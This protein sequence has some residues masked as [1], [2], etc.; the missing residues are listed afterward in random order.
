MSVQKEFSKNAHHYDEYNTIQNR[1][2]ED[3]IALGSKDEKNILDLGCG[4]GSV[5]KALKSEVDSFLGVD[6][7]AP[8][9]ELHPKSKNVKTVL[10]S[11]NDDELFTELAKNSYD[12]IYSASAL[13]W[14]TDLDQ[15]FK[16]IKELGTPISFS[17]FTSNTFKTIY[18]V[19]ELNPL[20]RSTEVLKEL[21]EKYFDATITTKNYKLEFESKSEMFSYIKNSGV[22]SGQRVLNYR[23]T[24]KLLEHYPI[25]YLEFEVMFIH[26]NF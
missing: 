6:F 8:M 2:V 18:E 25:N 21:I 4:S 23:Q 17:I 11:F 7:S 13:Q 20:L 9:L 14:A 10:G 19:T 1:V 22:S 24:K 26:Q 15:T 3:L 16:N 12:R 5:Y